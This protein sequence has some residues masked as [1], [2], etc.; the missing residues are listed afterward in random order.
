MRSKIN[1]KIKLIFTKENLVIMLF[2][3]GIIKHIPCVSD[4]PVITSTVL[5]CAMGVFAVTRLIHPNE[6]KFHLNIFAY[7]I[8]LSTL[9]S[10]IINGIED[11]RR[12][13]LS[14]IYLF[15]SL[16]IIFPTYTYDNYNTIFMSLKK[17]FNLMFPVCIIFEIYGLIKFGYDVIMSSADTYRLTGLFNNTNLSGWFLIFCIGVEAFIILFKNEYKKNHIILAKIGLS[18]SI[19]SLFLTQSRGAIIGVFVSAP[20]MVLLNNKGTSFVKKHKIMFLCG[21]TILLAILIIFLFF[22]NN[23]RGSGR[24]DIYLF[25]IK[26]FFSHNIL[27]GVGLENL[28]KIALQDYSIFNEQK[29][30]FEISIDYL[31]GGNTHNSL[32]YTLCIN[33]I[34]GFVF[35]FGFIIEII[36]RVIFVVRHSE[37]FIL[38]KQEKLLSI[39]LFFILTAL[40]IGM[41]D[42]ALFFS[43]ALSTNIMFC[44]CSGFLVKL[45]E[46]EREAIEKNIVN[47][48]EESMVVS[49]YY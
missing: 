23:R 25:Y 26:E 39:L 31:I 2:L 47:K 6:M 37:Y 20:F 48:A 43:M 8:I 34:V 17:I 30:M 1:E 40:V 44:L 9:L 38:K 49:K 28:G 32:L 10:F 36:L 13:V 42:N 24:E 22:I 21:S 5:I 11:L 19:V 18:I 27:F 4:T 35:A 14:I 3:Y 15:I 33:G 45:V 29:Q 16:I 12:V 7:G 41:F 46:N